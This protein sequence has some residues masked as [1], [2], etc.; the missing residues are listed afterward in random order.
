MAVALLDVSLGVGAAGASRKL[1]ADKVVGIAMM[2]T[3]G[4]LTAGRSTVPSA[5]MRAR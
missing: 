1:P 5:A 2:R 3:A 4:G